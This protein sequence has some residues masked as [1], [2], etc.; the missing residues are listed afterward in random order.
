MYIGSREQNDGHL[1]LQVGK[2]FYHALQG[3]EAVQDGLGPVLHPGAGGNDGHIAAPLIAGDGFI[4]LDPG[5]L[6]LHPDA[7]MGFPG[8]SDLFRG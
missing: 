7:G 6:A 1:L 8:E 4:Y 2:R 3:V 5:I